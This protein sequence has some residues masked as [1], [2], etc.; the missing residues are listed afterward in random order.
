[1]WKGVGVAMLL[2]G[3]AML[4]GALGGSRD[5]LRPLAFL[6]RTSAVESTHGFERIATMEAMDARLKNPG[7]PVMLDFY[8]DWCTSCKEMERNTFA[9]FQV[10]KSMQ[11]FVLLQVDVT[12]SSESDIRLLKHFGLV[13]PPGI[14]FFDA[15]G[16]EKAELRVIGYQAPEQFLATLSRAAT[17]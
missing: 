5:P 10:G 1:M 16:I 4:A 9:D 11:K 15:Q 12:A 6:T 8:A 17:Q 7:K 2:A 13:G 14:L 3:A